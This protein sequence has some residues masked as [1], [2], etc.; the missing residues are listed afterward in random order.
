MR[1]LTIPS[2]AAC[3][4]SL[5]VNSVTGLAFAGVAVAEEQVSGPEHEAAVDPFAAEVS[6]I[7]DVLLALPGHDIRVAYLEGVLKT[8]PLELMVRVRSG[9][10]VLMVLTDKP[11]DEER[12]RA[13]ASA[14]LAPD[15]ETREAALQAAVTGA[16]A[17]SVPES[18]VMEQPEPPVE[19]ADRDVLT[20]LAHGV[21]DIGWG[22]SPLEAQTILGVD[23]GAV[24][25]RIWPGP[26]YPEDLAVLVVPQTI[27]ECP[28][29]MAYLFSSGGFWRAW[30]NT[31]DTGCWSRLGAALQR[32]L[33]SSAER[34]R[35]TPAGK[36]LVREW[37]S[38]GRVTLG[39]ATE[40]EQPAGPVYLHLQPPL[41]TMEPPP[42]PGASIYGPR[43]G[44]RRQASSEVRGRALKRKAGAH[45]GVG[46]GL[47]AVALGTGAGT[48]AVWHGGEEGYSSGAFVGLGITSVATA[49][50]SAVFL[51]VGGSMDVRANFMLARSPE[52]RSAQLWVAAGPCNLHLTLRF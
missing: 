45:L 14:A 18:V 25:A 28:G 9:L 23:A 37:T 48:I 42:P 34:E 15:T 27:A 47:L 31:E 20:D 39:V 50:V 21:A 35:Y 40:R 3:I 16:P 38:G 8:A 1:G 6:E 22:A 52:K 11:A 4:L 49:T 30:F 33:G 2:L 19:K 29:E 13:L 46:F 41:G 51:V 26:R 44:D 32:G 43:R 12:T 17:P 36:M 5:I 10:A 7:I 24:A